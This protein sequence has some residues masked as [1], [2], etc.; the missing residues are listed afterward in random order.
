MSKIK[1]N[2]K[3][4]KIKSSENDSYTD[5]ISLICSIGCPMTMDYWGKVTINPGIDL[6]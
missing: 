6:N 4:S 1:K 5:G 3:D 2:I